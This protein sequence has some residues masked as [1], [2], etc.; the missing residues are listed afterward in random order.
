[1]QWACNFPLIE[2]F[3]CLPCCMTRQA[4]ME[5]EGKAPFPVLG[6]GIRQERIAGLYKGTTGQQYGG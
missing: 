6:Q 3:C 1:M 5:Q 4:L 2:E